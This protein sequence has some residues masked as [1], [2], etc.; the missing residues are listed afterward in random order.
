[1]PL[2][3]LL[4]RLALAATPGFARAR[5]FLAGLA[6]PGRILAGALV[7]LLV[8]TLGLV[9]CDGKAERA[10][11]HRQRAAAY[12]A[13]GAPERAA[14]E[15]RNA[16]RLDPVN[17][18]ARLDFARLLRGRGDLDQA[19]AQYEILVDQDRRN[20]DGQR[21]LAALALKVQ[22]FAAAGT[23]ARRAYELAPEDP[24]ARALKAALDYRAG[25]EDGDKAAALALARAVVETD[26]TQIPAQTVLIAE[27][28]EAED[29]AGALALAEAALAASPGDEGLHLVRLAALERL[30]DMAG[31]AAQL[32]RMAALFPTN[33]GVA[34]AQVRLRLGQGDVAGAEAV[35]RARAA[36]VPGDPER[37]LSVVRFLHDTQG[38]AAARAELDR[39]AAEAASP[40]PYQRLRATLDFSE[41]RAAEAIAALRALTEGAAPDD[42]TR[43]IQVDLAAMLAATGDAAGRDALVASVIAGDPGHVGA[44]KLRARA[45]I[46]ADAPERAVQD[47]RTA[48]TQAPRDPE[49]MTILA[50][51]HARA[52]APELAGERLSLAVEASGRAPDESLR[53]ARFLAQ[54]G[55]LDQAEAVIGDA[56]RLAPQDPGLLGALG[57]I[58]VARGDWGGAGRTADRLR[59]AG[60]PGGAADALDTARATG[61]GR[62][63]D[64]LALLR[65]RAE[66]GETAATAELLER[67]AAAGDVAA[68]QAWL[69]GRIE[70]APQDVQLRMMQAGLLAAEGRTA[71]AEAAYRALIAADPARPEPWRALFGLLADQGATEAA[72][73]VLAEGR[74]A[75]GDDPDLLFLEA[76]MREAA[77]DPEGAIA[78][79]ETLYARDSGNAVVANNLAS[80]LASHRDDAASLQ[81]AYLVARRLRG[82]DVPQFQD[83]YGWLLHRRGDS[84]Q[85][86][87]FLAPAA[88]ALPD[89]PLAQR[90]AAEALFALGRTAEARAAYARVLALSPTGPEAEAARAR[91]A[92][93]DA[94]SAPARSTAAETDG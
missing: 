11:A 40:L 58:Q 44:L 65:R 81:R 32:D 23:A 39:L 54:R 3:P 68:A 64:A 46:A 5:L 43:D 52:G 22:D 76:G 94:G 47:M 28:M 74:A 77:G 10:E 38:S 30:G 18:A 90:H 2:R 78:L 63:A 51:A 6:L 57:E 72:R 14:I 93:I 19:L 17:L 27:R 53:Y 34:R 82:S 8:A 80:L 71:E 4:S 45:A 91:I 73:G 89:N 1:M 61:E 26:P 85:A 21:E 79:Y 59:E 12:L 50:E 88:A 9:G 84:V 20:L 56:L 42:Q 86:L 33:E 87:T 48:L 15:L 37:A 67:L 62:S 31:Y 75:A 70:A 92:E 24:T 55:R 29:P 16:L 36:A 7:L 13:E 49:I 25:D 69:D 41:G 83:T 35:L 60:D 66:A